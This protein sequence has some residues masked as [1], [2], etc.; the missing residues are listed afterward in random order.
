MLTFSLFQRVRSALLIGFAVAATFLPMSGA[1][2]AKPVTVTITQLD[3]IGEDFDPTSLGDFY[4]KVTING[5][6][7][8]T[9]DKRFNFPGEITTDFIAPSGPLRSWLVAIASEKSKLWLSV[10]IPLATSLL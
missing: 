3:Q 6:A 9:K 7:F 5:T 2:Q 10:R 1:A 4:A 8:D